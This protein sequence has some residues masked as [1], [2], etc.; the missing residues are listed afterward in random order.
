MII[1][2]ESKPIQWQSLKR[3]YHKFHYL[4]LVVCLPVILFLPIHFFTWHPI[5]RYSILHR[6]WCT[7]LIGLKKENTNQNKTKQKTRMKACIDYF[8]KNI[9]KWQ[10]HLLPWPLMVILR[11]KNLIH[12]IRHFTTKRWK[13]RHTND[14]PENKRERN[15]ARAHANN[16]PLTKIENSA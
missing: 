10:Y 16:E 5:S 9:I 15:L 2:R 11:R 8:C 13:N 14:K 12:I 4:K 7:D 6:V 1:R 3:I